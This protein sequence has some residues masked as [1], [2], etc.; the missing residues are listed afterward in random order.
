MRLLFVK[1]VFL[2]IHKFVLELQF[3]VY[4]CSYSLPMVLPICLATT[5]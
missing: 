4:D 3:T 5:Y 1:I 2:K